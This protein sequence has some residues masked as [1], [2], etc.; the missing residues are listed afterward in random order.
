M[1]VKSRRKVL[2]GIAD[3]LEYRRTRDGR[4]FAMLPDAG[5][6]EVGGGVVSEYLTRV[7]LDRVHEPPWASDLAAVLRA[8]LACERHQAP[9]AEVELRVVDDTS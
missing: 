1:D 4:V 8:V 5:P 7:Y 6:H 2:M 3:R 9:L